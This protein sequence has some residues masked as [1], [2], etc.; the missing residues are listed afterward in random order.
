M[1][2]YIIKNCPAIYGVSPDGC[3]K[4]HY[5]D[6]IVLCQ[7]CTDCVMKQIYEMCKSQKESSCTFAVAFLADRILQLLDIQEVADE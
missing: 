3:K 6:G 2:K 4:D 5:E 1:S 7:D